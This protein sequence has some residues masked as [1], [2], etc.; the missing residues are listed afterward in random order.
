MRWRQRFQRSARPHAANNPAPPRVIFSAQVPIVTG[1]RQMTKTVSASQASTYEINASN[2]SYIFAEGRTFYD[3]DSA[4]IHQAATFSNNTILINGS[5]SSAGGFGTV[6][7]DI[8]GSANTVL[9]DEG[10]SITG[11]GG[12]HMVGADETFKNSGLV[13][14]TGLGSA[15]TVEG[16]R[17]HV[18]NHNMIHGAFGIGMVATSGGLIEN[19]GA[20]QALASGI[21]AEGD[22]LRISLGVDSVVTSATI[23]VQIQSNA[24]DLSKTVNEGRIATVGLT[25][26]QGSAGDETLINR[27][28][29]SGDVKLDDGNDTFDT[30]SGAFIGIVY[31][32]NGNDV[33]DVDSATTKIMEMVGQGDDTVKSTVSLSLARPSLAASDLENLTLLGKADLHAT[34]NAGSNHITGNSGNN[35]LNGG[36]GLDYLIGGKGADRFI[37]ASGNESDDILDFGRGADVVDLSGATGISSFNDLMKHHVDQDKGNIYIHTGTD[38]LILENMSKADL[39][40]QQFIF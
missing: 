3:D 13:L 26:F 35:A 11:S 31:G 6:G 12:I 20:I 39:H 17:A 40:A 36:A 21:V 29:V 5:V 8:E 28:L 16:V 4:A 1:D 27:G 9:V 18:V 30:R 38:E 7:M 24:G 19:D 22:G 34:G 23:G 14:A 32:G 15:V 25:A 33:Y 10:G 2:T 37:F